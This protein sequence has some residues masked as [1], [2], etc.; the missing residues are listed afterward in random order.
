MSK[1]MGRNTTKNKCSA[2]GLETT[3]WGG[4]T[5]LKPKGMRGDSNYWNQGPKGLCGEGPLT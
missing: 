1:D 4:V 3:R 2:P 5:L